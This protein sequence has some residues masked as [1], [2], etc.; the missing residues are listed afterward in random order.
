MY[1]IIT[2]KGIYKMINI[3]IA[4]IIKAHSID[5][6]G[7]YKRITKLTEEHG[8]LYEA[9]MS[10][11]RLNVLE[12]G[13]D[14]L[15]VLVSLSYEIDNRCLDISQLKTNQSFVQKVNHNIEPF[16]LIAEYSINI[17]KMSDTLQKYDNI[18]SSQYKGKSTLDNALDSIY[19]AIDSLMKFLL[20]FEPTEKELN[21]LIIKKMTKWIEKVS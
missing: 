4:Q 18:I 1:I 8:E 15:V 5:K 19:L 21:A 17:G 2:A 11:E 16:F 9:F 13:V 7:M 10:N 14:N 12:E 20:I 3:S 6:R